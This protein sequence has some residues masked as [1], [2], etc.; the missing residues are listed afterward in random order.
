MTRQNPSHFKGANL[1]VDNVN[2]D[3]A[4]AYCAAIGGRLPTEAEWEYSARAGS[5]GAGYG[6]LDDIAWYSGNSGGK[7]NEVGQKQANALGLFD[8]LGNVWQWTAD[9]YGGYG[10]YPSGAQSDPSG[11]AGGALRVL[12]GGAW[13][14]IPRFVRVTG[15][16]GLRPGSRSYNFGFRCVGE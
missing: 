12:R 10:G 4:S 2:W 15:R 7:T 5:T 1:P 16:Q 6:N 3:K 13:I 14:G 8:M 9:W 11:P